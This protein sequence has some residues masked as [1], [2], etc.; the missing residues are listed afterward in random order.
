MVGRA[1][2]T[3]AFCSSRFR[4]PE[5]GQRLALGFQL[6]NHR[7]FGFL[8]VFVFSVLAR[9]NKVHKKVKRLQIEKRENNSKTML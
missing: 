1:V 9:D 4:L 7:R 2:C 5:L 6:G 3:E 8:F